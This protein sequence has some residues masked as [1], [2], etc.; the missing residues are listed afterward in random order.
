[1]IYTPITAEFHSHSMTQSVSW[2]IRKT[3][4][5]QSIF[6]RIM[7]FGFVG[8]HS[9]PRPRKPILRESFL[10]CPPQKRGA[11]SGEKSETP[12]EGKIHTVRALSTNILTRALLDVNDLAVMIH[13]K[14]ALHRPE[15]TGGLSKLPLHNGIGQALHPSAVEDNAR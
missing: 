1:M 13:E 3:T 11:S 8:T 4:G 14:Q 6:P 15:A 5:P 10:A 9:V 12:A 2:M 7:G